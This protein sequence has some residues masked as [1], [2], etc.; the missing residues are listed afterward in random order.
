MV[1]K[2]NIKQKNQPM[3]LLRDETTKMLVIVEV[4]KLS[5]FNKMS[6]I[7]PGITV[8]WQDSMKE[9]YRGPILNIG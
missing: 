7:V 6:K 5:S 3:A 1:S 2:T 8:N 9:R 4:K